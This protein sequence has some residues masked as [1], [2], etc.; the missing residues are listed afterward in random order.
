MNPPVS[1]A[2]QGGFFV[3]AIVTGL[4]FGAL[5]LVFQEVT[6]GLGCLLG[7]FCLSMW[8]LMLSPGGLIKS[9]AG[10]VI[11]IGCMTVGAFCLSLSHWTRTYGLIACI[12]FSGAMATVLGIDC[13]SRAGMKELWLY[14]WGEYSLV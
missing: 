11:F 5:S 10:K 13:F 2:V 7:G 8:F 9:T 4:I 3:A 6:E 14:I 1:D 12:S